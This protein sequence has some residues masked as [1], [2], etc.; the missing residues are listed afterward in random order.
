MTEINAEQLLVHLGGFLRAHQA[1]AKL[2]LLPGASFLLQLAP[3][4]KDEHLEIFVCPGDR[5]ARAP[6]VEPYRADWKS[7]PCSYRGPTAEFL[8]KAAKGEAPERYVLACDRNGPDGRAPHHAGGV[9]VLWNDSTVQFVRWEEMEGY[10]GG[11]VRVGPGSPDPRFTH[12]V[13]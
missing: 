10:E 7:A 3:K 9:A 4:V 8:E 12:L 5:S 2:E 11:P 6:A 13:E 1:S